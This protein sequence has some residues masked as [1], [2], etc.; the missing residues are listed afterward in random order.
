MFARLG[1]KL[2]FATAAIAVVFFGVG[3]IGLA[4]ATALTPYI[5]AAL[6]L[7]RGGRH[8]AAAAAAWS[9]HR[10]RPPAQET[11]TGRRP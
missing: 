11:V 2:V 7:W 9:C 10:F 8:P 3:L 5:G 1:A 4:I 6:R